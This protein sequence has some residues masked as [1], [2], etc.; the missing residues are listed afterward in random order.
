VLRLNPET[1]AAVG[2]AILAAVALYFNIKSTRAAVRAAQASEEQSVVQR[3]LRV[4]AS[5]P[6]LWADIRLDDGSQSLLNFVIG[7]SGPTVATGVRVTVEPPLPAIDELRSRAESAQARLADGIQSLTPG[8]VLTW[9]L[10]QGFRLLNEEGHQAYT[11]TVSAIGPFGPVPPLSYVIDMS[12]WRGLL[13]R[14]AGSL[15]QLTEAVKDLTK[16]IDGR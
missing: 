13:H 16:K 1:L 6:Y 11:V 12:D 2:A 9:P 5:Q 3:Q 8:R 15:Y 7:N 4:D 10:G 14:P